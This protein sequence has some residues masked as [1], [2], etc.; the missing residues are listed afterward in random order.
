LLLARGLTE[1]CSAQPITRGRPSEERVL[2]RTQAIKLP[3]DDVSTMRAEIERA[4]TPN[5]E[6]R[7]PTQL[8]PEIE[9]PFSPRVDRNPEARPRMRASMGLRPSRIALIMVAIIAGGIAA[10]LALQ[11]S[12]P[13]PEPVQEVV[14]EVVPAP[15]TQVLVANQPIAVGQKLSPESLA[16]ID[17][18]QAAMQPEYI[19]N[20]TMP[21]AMT[22]MSDA[23]A[24]SEFFAGEP[25]REQKL[26]RGGNGF[27]SVVL[28]PGMRAVS[29]AISS[30]SASGGFVLPEDRVDVVLTRG[31]ETGPESMT[32][33]SNV[34]VL[35]INKQLGGTE[36][37]ESEG[38]ED[39]A[40]GFDGMAVATLALDQPQAEMVA[41]AQM[42]GKLTLVLRPMADSATPSTGLS[43]ANQAIRLTSPFWNRTTNSN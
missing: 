5:P 30:E 14:T 10:Y 3:P 42:L 17:W 36:P 40:A 35:A 21:D 19:T 27:L 13:A 12:P 16:W 33:L 29:V 9:R 20:E 23:I 4:F 8:P 41:S 37:S 2:R 28:E 32:I 7:D 31:S 11:R 43:T 24:R 15:V 39:G 25:I 18:P 1:L 22:E 26:A 34:R 6:L 38:E